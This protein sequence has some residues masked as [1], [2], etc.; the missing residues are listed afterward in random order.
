MLARRQAV[1]AAGSRDGSAGNGL[2]GADVL[3]RKPLNDDGAAASQADEPPP[4]PKNFL[5]YCLL[6]MLS[7]RP[8]YGYQL[9]EQLA[10]FALHRDRGR[11]Y[12]MLGALEQEGLVTSLWATSKIGP[13]RHMYELTRA[14]EQALDS[15]AQELKA[16]HEMLERFLDLYR[17]RESKA[18]WLRTHPAARSGPGLD[19][20]GEHDRRADDRADAD[21]DP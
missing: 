21:A 19:G 12:R 10:P 6:V 2:A 8:A 13:D 15:G 20:L 9:L 11:M 17:I 1:L 5:R 14:G 18:L 7:E 3:S 4:R 16:T